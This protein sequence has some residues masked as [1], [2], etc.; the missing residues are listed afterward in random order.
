[1]LPHPGDPA[2]PPD[3]GNSSDVE[4][5][6]SQVV[7]RILA[8]DFCQEKVSEDGSTYFAFQVASARVETNSVRIRADGPACGCGD[9]H[10]RHID[11]LLNR[12]GLNAA[13]AHHDIDR[14][15]LSHLCDENQAEHRRDEGVDSQATEW[16]LRKS[17]LGPVSNRQSQSTFHRRMQTVR[18]VMATLSSDRIRE[19]Y[20]YDIFDQ[21][22][23]DLIS[24]PVYTANDLEACICKLML[25][26]DEFD[27]HLR[28][29]VTPQTRDLDY[30][31]KF[32]SKAET[33]FGFH[34][35]YI[36]TGTWRDWGVLLPA[37]RREPFP[38]DVAWCALELVR[39]TECIQAR[40][41]RG[42]M[43]L[44]A[45]EA[46]SDCLVRL[47]DS[48]IDRNHDIYTNISWKRKAPHGE[49]TSN[50]NLYQNLFGKDSLQSPARGQFVLAVL[51]IIPEACV[52]HVGH[53]Q[54]ILEI[55][56]G[57]GYDATP[58]YRERLAAFVHRLRGLIAVMPVVE[59]PAHI[60]APRPPLSAHGGHARSGSVGSKR[61]ATSPDRQG[62]RRML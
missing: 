4:T 58:A 55:I 49:R 37:T 17:Y 30:M 50:R 47:L 11:W 7:E 43:A 15:G 24:S 59:S 22:D 25:R 28:S 19:E 18:D 29:M 1:M 2:H 5:D 56:S 10:C 35:D 20:R 21:T 32:Q 53:L 36:S 52:R 40:C 33:V 60:S 12:L 41:S 34:D 23:A 14:M 48:V 8:L 51:E 9:P 6:S 42:A 61:A 54:S 46:A 62:K 27:H 57:P 3:D 39:I 44:S 38:H 16:E 45:K 13:E 26:N 31:A